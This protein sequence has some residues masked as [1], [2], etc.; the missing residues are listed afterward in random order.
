MAHNDYQPNS[1]PAHLHY[2]AHV[3]SAHPPKK[4]RD[5]LTMG[6]A[7]SM[8]VFLIVALIMTLLSGFILHRWIPQVVLMG[9][10]LATSFASLFGTI[11]FFSRLDDKQRKNR[12]SPYSY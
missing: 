10:M 3:E 5:Y 7:L 8:P 1:F 12:K 4:E 6:I 9:L 2:P 11:I